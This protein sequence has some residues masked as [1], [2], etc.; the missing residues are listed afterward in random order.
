MSGVK[1]NEPYQRVEY[2]NIDTTKIPA[3]GFYGKLLKRD[4]SNHLKN[5]I[6]NT[7]EFNKKLSQIGINISGTKQQYWVKY[8]DLVFCAPVC[9][10]YDS[11]LEQIGNSKYSVIITNFRSGASFTKQFRGAG[12]NSLTKCSL[13]LETR[14]LYVKIKQV[15]TT[16]LPSDLIEYCIAI[17]CHLL[18]NNLIKNIIVV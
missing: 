5:C 10:S 13:Y 4:M 7:T 1:N 14:E 6:K 2:L 8:K 17:Y 3:T 12:V 18:G 9:G 16:E 15:M 11:I